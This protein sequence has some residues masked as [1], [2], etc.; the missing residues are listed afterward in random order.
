M[1]RRCAGAIEVLL[2]HPGGPFFAKKDEGAWTVPKGLVG[3]GEDPL[4]AAKRE[5]TEETSF[6]I[7]TERFLPLGEVLQKGGKA[8]VAWAFEGDCDP[9]CLASNTYELEYPAKSGRWKSYPEVDRAQ[10][11]S[12]EVARAKLNPAQAEFVER[13]ERALLGEAG[14]G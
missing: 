10:W 2:A 6:P 9:A 4:D 8:V 7:G 1:Y 11:C 13:L 3:E 12:P 14:D 5:F